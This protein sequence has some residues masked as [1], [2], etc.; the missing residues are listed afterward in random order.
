MASAAPQ[1]GALR[2]WLSRHGLRVTTPRV[3]VLEMLIDQAEAIDAI[4]LHLKVR[5]QAPKISLGTVYRTLRELE[6]LRVVDV[7]V[8]PHGRLRWQLHAGRPPARDN[9]REHPPIS[10]KP[11]SAS[12]QSADDLAALARQAKRL[13]YRL[14]PLTP[15][16]HRAA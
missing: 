16:R 9:Q 11:A 1:T 2:D 7:S 5:T 6:R 15:P 12:P 8:A 4:Q 14:V 10:A 13:G 3:A